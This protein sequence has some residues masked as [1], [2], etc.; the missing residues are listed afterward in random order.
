M[1]FWE[2]AMHKEIHSINEQIQE[3]AALFKL[4]AIKESFSSIAQ[5]AAKENLSYTQF[6]HRLF[7]YE[8]Q[9]KIERSK[10]TTLKMAGFPKVKP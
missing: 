5:E 4:P 6:L 10:A 7:A 3:Y 2:F 8:Y 9:T 1:R